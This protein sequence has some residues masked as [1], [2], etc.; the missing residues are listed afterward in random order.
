MHKTKFFKKNRD[1]YTNKKD[2]HQN[3]FMNSVLSNMM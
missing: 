1:H 2:Q 3:E